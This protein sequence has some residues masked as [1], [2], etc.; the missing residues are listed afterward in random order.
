[1]EALAMPAQQG[2]GLEEEQ[3]FFPVGETSCQ[4]KKPE[5]VRAGEV[6]FLHLPLED[7]QLVAEQGIFC[8]Q[9]SFTE[10]EIS[11]GAQGQGRASRLSETTEGLIQKR[12]QI[13]KEM[14]LKVKKERHR[15]ENPGQAVEYGEGMVVGVLSPSNCGRTRF[16]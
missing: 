9:L 12:E 14:G 15:A 10:R 5:A 3:S 13:G 1:M 2:L 4:E 16:L 6:R 11:G 8:D 7:N